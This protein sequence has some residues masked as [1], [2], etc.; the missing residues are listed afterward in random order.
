[1]VSLTFTHLPKRGHV[2]KRY[3]ARKREKMFGNKIKHTFRVEI[4]K[5]RNILQIIDFFLLGESKKKRKVDSEFLFFVRLRLESL[6][7]ICYV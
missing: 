6:H 4:F 1:M 2:A 3:F 7:K 5:A